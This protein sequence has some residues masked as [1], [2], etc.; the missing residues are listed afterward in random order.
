[1][2]YSA[3]KMLS[4]LDLFLSS[5]YYTLIQE[6]FLFFPPMEPFTNGVA[7]LILLAALTRISTRGVYLT[8]SLYI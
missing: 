4:S 7:L 5:I 6:S 2:K 1:M 8:V 3:G